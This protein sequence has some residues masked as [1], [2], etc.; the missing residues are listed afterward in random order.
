MQLLSFSYDEHYC[1]KRFIG[2]KLMT[3]GFFKKK[4]HQL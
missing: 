1:T 2:E 4:I 3:I